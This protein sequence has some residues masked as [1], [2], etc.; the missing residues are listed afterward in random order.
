[1]GTYTVVDNFLGDVEYQVI[2]FVLHN[3][4]WYLEDHQCQTDSPYLQHT[5][6]SKDHI[7]DRFDAVSVF[8]DRL[9]VDQW[10]NVRANLYMGGVNQM[11]RDIF[12]DRDHKT[13]IYY[14]NGKGGLNICG[15]FVPAKENRVVLLDSTV[16][17]QG[18]HDFKKMVINFNYDI[19]PHT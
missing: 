17:H 4:P 3:L 13:A 15:D 10:I 12:A 7:S 19:S 18:V 5:F 2:D 9:L 11:H 6:Y 14:H 8:K 1:M 16:E